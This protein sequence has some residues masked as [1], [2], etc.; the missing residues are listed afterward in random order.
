MAKENPLWVAKDVLQ[1]KGWTK[2]HLEAEDGSVCA[3]GAMWFGCSVH[4]LPDPNIEMGV[5]ILNEVVIEQWPDR[6]TSA[7]LHPRN[8]LETAQFNDHPDTTLDDVLATFD[9]AAV[10]WEEIY[11]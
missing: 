5:N 7:E 9:K 2:G 8:L 1:E 4:V 3:L 11:G 10:R 6:A